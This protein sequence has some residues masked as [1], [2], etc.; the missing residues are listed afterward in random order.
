MT[1]K[2]IT[3]TATPGGPR[4]ADCWAALGLCLAVVLWQ[5]L[6]PEYRRPV[7]DALVYA[8][9]AL[10]LADAWGDP[11]RS[12][13]GTFRIHLGPGYPAFLSLFAV[14][15][16][17]LNAT[18]RCLVD[19]SAACGLDGLTR[20]FAVQGCLAALSTF[21]VFLAA[22]RLTGDRRA[23]WLALVLVLATKMNAGYASQVLTEALAFFFLFLFAWLLSLVATAD[24]PTWPAAA[25]AG[26]A[27]AATVLVRPSYGLLVYFMAAALFLWALWPRRLGPVRAAG[28]AGAFTGGAFV[29][30]APWVAR[31]AVVAGIAAITAGTNESVLIE[32]LAYNAMTWREWAV[33]FVYW[34]PDFGD[35]L[36]KALFPRDA[37]I[38]L[39][40]YDPGSFY[41]MGRGDHARTLREAAWASGD[42]FGYLVRN[43]L[44]DDLPKHVMVTL[45]LAWRGMWAGKYLGVAGAVL[46][47]VCV[48]VL[49]RRGRAASL[50][51][52][53]LP[54]VF[55]LGLYAFATVNVVRYNDPLIALYALS[56]A[57]V[58]VYLADRLRAGRAARG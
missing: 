2:P 30:L 10:D 34:M 53:S 45:A 19:P 43:H 23:A 48:W 27:L 4:A 32:R 24:R 15:D 47:P 52:W 9:A 13:I 57:V 36:A 12:W 7:A 25:L 11:A 3:G 8:G 37:Y 54:S 50:L 5:T 46:L 18:L 22:G 29:M 41:S 33:S 17:V 31:N 42:A 14:A 39:S 56:V 51:L 35:D 1:T 55:M 16:P 26:L 6:V 28:L 44:L 21:F 38:R 20:L 40:W 58:L 49:A